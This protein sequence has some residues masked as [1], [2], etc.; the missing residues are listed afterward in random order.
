MALT[1]EPGTT[2]SSG[3]IRAASA[4]HPAMT[5]DF[6]LGHLDQVNRLID[7]SGRS[8][9]VGEL[10][11]DSGVPTVIPKLEAYA[12]AHLRAEDR[13]PIDQAIGRI[14]WKAENQP[15]IHREVDAWL[16]SQ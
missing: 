13:R 2:V 1:P 3:M 8:R 11:E 12:K 15:R 5:L 16:K 4:K 6:V 14:R 9:F 7:L 10:V